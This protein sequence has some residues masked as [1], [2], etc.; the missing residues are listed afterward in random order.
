MLLEFPEILKKF[1]V[2][3]VRMCLL[4]FY[5]FASTFFRMKYGILRDFFL[6]ENTCDETSSSLLDRAAYN[7]IYLSQESL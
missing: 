1:P 2:T 7:S 4:L 6:T 3:A 5:T